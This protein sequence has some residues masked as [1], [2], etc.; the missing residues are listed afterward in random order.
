MGIYLFISGYLFNI[1]IT[2]ASS[3]FS[4]QHYK[5]FLRMHINSNGDLTI[6]PV[7]IKKIV[8]QW[9]QNE[10]EDKIIFTSDETPDLFLIEPPIII[11]NN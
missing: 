8:T 4:Y 3:S 1:H 5:N 2:E 7:G 10:T 11:K 9:N 6:Y